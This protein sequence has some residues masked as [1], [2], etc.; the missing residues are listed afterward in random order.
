[1]LSMRLKKVCDYVDL[2]SKVNREM[3]ERRKNKKRSGDRIEDRES[4]KRVT[5]VFEEIDK[6]FKEIYVRS[7]SEVSYRLVNDTE[8]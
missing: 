6:L 4:F 5:E 7:I 2:F 1:M 8:I 3:I